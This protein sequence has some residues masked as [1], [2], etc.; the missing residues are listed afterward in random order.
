M[1]FRPVDGCTRS[2]ADVL[3]IL[4]R[5]VVPLGIAA[6]AVLW[7]FFGGVSSPRESLVQS[8]LDMRDGFN[9]QSAGDVLR[10]CSDDF[11]ESVYSL[12]SAS[13]RGALVRI[14]LGQRD[15]SDRSFL[16]QADVSEDAVEVVFDGIEEE[17]VRASVSAA[18]EF[19]RR[20]KPA[21]KPVWVLKIEGEAER[22]ADGR[23]R[24]QTASFK[25]LSG[26]R[27]F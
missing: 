2:A 22:E 9:H 10:H 25:T 18:V 14:F 5:G 23:W 13:F 19:R 1:E 4:I 15:R 12:D 20:K 16:W 7:L 24:F 3:R 11:S 6:V 21:R 8:I 27:P 26:R 17:A